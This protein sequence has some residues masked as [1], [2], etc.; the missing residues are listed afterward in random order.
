MSGFV[1]VD[2]PTIPDAAENRKGLCAKCHAPCP[3]ASPGI[4]N[5]DMLL[6]S[7]AACSEVLISV[8]KGRNGGEGRGA[9]SGAPT[10]PCTHAHSCRGAT[11]RAPARPCTPLHASCTTH[12]LV[13]AP[14]A[15]PRILSPPPCLFPQSRPSVASAVNN[16]N[17][18]TLKNPGPL[19]QPRAGILVFALRNYSPTTIVSVQPPISISYSPASSVSGI[20]TTRQE[21]PCTV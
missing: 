10:C 15:A 2:T 3:N 21:P 13:G 12:I 19:S 5:I 8:R 14:L 11:C 1:L 20:S 18:C 17:I 9:A 4:P 16:N 6:G 7:P